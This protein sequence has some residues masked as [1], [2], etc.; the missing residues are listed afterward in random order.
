MTINREKAGVIIPAAGSGSRMEESLPKQFLKLSE[1]PILIHTIAAFLKVKEISSLS[2]AIAQKHKQLVLSLLTAHFTPEEQNKIIITGGGASRQ[3]SVQ[4]GLSAM[5]EEVQIILVHDG[6]RP[7]VSQALIRRC[8]AG[9]VLYG[10]VIAALEVHDT[11]KMATNKVITTTINRTG[12]FRAQT[13]QAARRHLL[14][15]AFKKAEEDGFIGT[16]EAS[17]FEHAGI[18]VLIVA[19]EKQNLKITRSDDLALAEVI[20]TGRAEV[21]KK[22]TMRIGH[23]FDAHRLV[24]DRKLILGGEEIEFNLGLAGHSD[25]DVLSH[26][27]MDAILGAIGEGDIG[28]HFPD[29][30]KKYRGAES[31]LLLGKVIDLAEQKDFHLNNADIT[32]I[33]QKPRLAPY[34][35]QMTANLAEI[36]KT[37]PKQINIK[38]TTTEHMGYTGRG[39]G[40]SCHA[41]ILMEEK[42]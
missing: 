42:T 7:L 9:A 37:S 29:S 12:L 20:L 34:L 38:A 17:L 32:I 10:A 26:A 36:C 28:R 31:L 2:V 3:L 16:D 15:N 19:G 25:A 33:C 27:L 39:E 6:A 30:D 8:I 5:P 4:A 1:I 14:E 35:Q 40:I 22:K 24:K 11:L 21:G 13:P 41:V 23:G 18:P